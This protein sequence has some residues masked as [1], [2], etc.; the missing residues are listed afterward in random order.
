MDGVGRKEKGVLGIE[1][2]TKL[3]ITANTIYGQ[4]SQKRRGEGG[5]Y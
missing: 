4:G 3:R 5:D 2:Q 1:T